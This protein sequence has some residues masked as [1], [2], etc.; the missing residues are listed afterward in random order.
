[1][2]LNVKE[3]PTITPN[4][5]E[6]ER[7]TADNITETPD[8][9]VDEFKVLYHTSFL[10]SQKRSEK[11]AKEMK[12]R[13]LLA[14]VSESDAA[15]EM[16]RD[17]IVIPPDRPP[18]RVSF[19]QGE[20]EFIP[21]HQVESVGLRRD[22]EI[23]SA[24][25]QEDDTMSEIT[26]NNTAESM[27][28]GSESIVE[29]AQNARSNVVIPEEEDY[30]PIPLPM[31]QIKRSVM[32]DG[33]KRSSLEKSS[34]ESSRSKRDESLMQAEQT[35]LDESSVTLSDISSSIKFQAASSS[36]DPA[37][38]FASQTSSSRSS[39]QPRSSP[40]NSRHTESYQATYDPLP[41]DNSSMPWSGASALASVSNHSDSAF[42]RS[43]HS[44]DTIETVPSAELQVQAAQ[45]ATTPFIEKQAKSKELI[46]AV[47][48]AVCEPVEESDIPIKAGRRKSSRNV[49]SVVLHESMD[50]SSGSRNF[51]ER[52]I[53]DEQL[54]VLTRI[55]S[56]TRRKKMG[57]KKTVSDSSLVDRDYL[58]LQGLLQGTGPQRLTT[59]EPALDYHKS[60]HSVG[61]EWEPDMSIPDES[62]HPL[63]PRLPSN[64][65]STLSSGL[66]SSVGPSMPD[67]PSIPDSVSDYNVFHNDHVQ[68]GK[69][70]DQN[71]V[72][73]T[74]ESYSQPLPRAFIVSDGSED[75]VG[76]LSDYSIVTEESKYGHSRKIKK[77]FCIIFIILIL[78]G[79]AVALAIGLNGYFKPSIGSGSGSSPPS[80]SPTMEIPLTRQ[81][82][83]NA[84]LEVS[85]DGGAAIAYQGTPQHR[86]FEW[87]VDGNE[88]QQY[89]SASRY[90]QRFALATLYFST[91]GD[92]W[93][94][95]EKWLSSDDEC[96]WF[97]RANN[98][99][100]ALGDIIEVDLSELGLSGVIPE[101][102]GMLKGLKLLNLSGNGII[103][104]M[105]KSLWT[106]QSL[107]KSAM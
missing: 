17:G 36:S 59:S 89:S 38:N 6:R 103:R 86:A 2:Q 27:A 64:D 33:I 67:P 83:L 78:A 43:I 16:L 101:E 81:E 99:C 100:G 75:C 63:Q 69:V 35:M 31:F 26:D 3:N 73:A 61:F 71:V 92:K 15:V 60:T 52:K 44:G 19:R 62:I 7:L 5:G 56:G 55:K 106:L 28:A 107:S 84:I 20:A 50:S 40:S 48:L 95:N 39:G 24:P 85:E 10:L 102:I 80:S 66:G 30:F 4:Q 88:P 82:V 49:E 96:L 41:S 11:D 25:A 34:S 53:T 51:K 21:M 29:P 23:V 76:V 68:E 12:F 42:V 72:R 13:N 91:E 37:S 74:V 22:K 87:L 8:N 70:L 47:P 104:D 54:L 65:G 97:N 14:S 93:T 32:N 57:S 45:R 90:I 77:M 94:L 58:R 46:T 98:P 1:M 18:K 79:A 105:P 9:V